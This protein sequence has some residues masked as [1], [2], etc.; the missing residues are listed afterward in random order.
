MQKEKLL[1]KAI[2][3]SR[4]YNKWIKNFRQCSCGKKVK[5]PGFECTQPDAKDPTMWPI[6]NKKGSQINFNNLW[7]APLTGGK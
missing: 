5:M 4:K 6:T 7:Q 3:E 2:A 1:F